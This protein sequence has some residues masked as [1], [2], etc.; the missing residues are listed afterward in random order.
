MRSVVNERYLVFSNFLDATSKEYR[1]CISSP[2]LGG[3]CDDRFG[4][5][6]VGTLRTFVDSSD[7]R[8]DWLLKDRNDS[9]ELPNQIILATGSRHPCSRTG[10]N[11]V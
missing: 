2:F 4:V 8:S 11:F 9:T 10:G 6:L 7:D 5:A 3:L 1:S